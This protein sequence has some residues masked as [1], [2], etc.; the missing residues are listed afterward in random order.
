[1]LIRPLYDWLLRQAEKPYAHWL[2]FIVAVIE[3]CL[4]PLPPDALMIP[5][6]IARRDRAF[7]YAAITTLGSLTGALIGYG[8]GA[9]ALAT[10]GHWIIDTYSLQTTFDHFRHGFR[11]WGMLVIIAKGAIPVIPVPFFLVPFASGVVHFG[12]AKFVAAILIARGGRF[13][14]G[15]GLIYK[16]GEPIRYFIE[17]YLPWVAFAIIAGVALWV[18]AVVR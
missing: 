3:P 15:A 7:R 14:V 10:V 11:K 5:M 9:L 18:W 17:R 8:I 16:F 1:M 4:F 13:F 2:L 6:A 12:L